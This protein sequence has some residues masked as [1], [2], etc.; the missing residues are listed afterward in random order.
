M[1]IV[2]ESIFFYV[3]I[4]NPKIIIEE[5]ET[6]TPLDNCVCHKSVTMLME[7]LC[8][9]CVQVQTEYFLTIPRK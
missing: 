5:A 3:Q 9:Y 2:G 4:R 1:L 8:I 7:A 6:F